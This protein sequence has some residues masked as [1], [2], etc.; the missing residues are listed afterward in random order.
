[1]CY[2][3]AYPAAFRRSAHRFFIISERRFLTSGDNRRRLLRG[4]GD[5]F[6]LDCGVALCIPGN[7][8]WMAAISALTCAK[9]LAAPARAKASS[10]S[11]EIATRPLT[12]GAYHVRLVSRVGILVSGANEAYSVSLPE[13][14][15]VDTNLS[16]FG[17]VRRVKAGDAA[18]LERLILR[19]LPRLRLWARHRL[20]PWARDLAETED[21][22]QETL[23]N[24]VRN[25]HGFEMR[26]EHSLRSYM[27]SAVRNRVQDEIKR[28]SRHPAGDSLTETMSAT[29]PSPMRQAIA[30]EDFWRCRAALARL[31]PADR[32]LILTALSEDLTFNELARRLDMRS[33]D[34]ARIAL[35]RAVQ[36]LSR[37]MKVL[38]S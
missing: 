1:M 20:P 8:R 36:R 24:A 12:T 30:R 29:E 14:H 27:K 18:A 35:N 19:Y 26:D 28:V 17:L 13:V 21:L 31:K 37:E 9:R 15:H 32:R 16:S 6:P 33:A 22:V 25:L 38:E 5:L 10:S 2:L 11:F 23:F 3:A 34:T 7:V 4:P